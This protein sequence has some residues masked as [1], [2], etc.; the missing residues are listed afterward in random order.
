M[1]RGYAC[2]FPY[3]LVGPRCESISSRDFGVPFVSR[4]QWETVFENFLSGRGCWELLAGRRGDYMSEGG[5]RDWRWRRSGVGNFAV[6][7]CEWRTTSMWRPSCWSWDGEAAEGRFE[8]KLWLCST[9][10]WLWKFSGNSWNQQRGE[11][12]PC[13]SLI[14]RYWAWSSGII[15]RW[16]RN[17]L[18]L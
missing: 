3:L 2:P 15:L 16:G 6:C 4:C 11:T 17:W 10:G 8:L 13:R 12:S 9:G 1:F 5:R 7:S 14:S 18:V